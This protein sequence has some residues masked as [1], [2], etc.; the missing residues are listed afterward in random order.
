[1][2]GTL[3]AYSRNDLVAHAREAKEVEGKTIIVRGEA[4]LNC[5]LYSSL[6]FQSPRFAFRLDDAKVSLKDLETASNCVFQTL[7]WIIGVLRMESSTFDGI[8][9]KNCTHEETAKENRY[10]VT[11]NHHS[12]LSLK[13]HSQSE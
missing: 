5:G 13:D 8:M 10:I 3:A 11:S 2:E 4:R 6:P 1:M 12:L 9:R 7:K